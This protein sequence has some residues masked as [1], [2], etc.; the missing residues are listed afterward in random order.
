MPGVSGMFYFETNTFDFN[1]KNTF[2]S[3]R[4]KFPFIY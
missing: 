2:H 1:Y 4:T 3:W